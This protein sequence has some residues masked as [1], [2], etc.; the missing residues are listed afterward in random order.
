MP[1]GKRGWN[2]NFEKHITENGTIV[3][4]FFLHISKE[5][6][7]IEAFKKKKTQLEVLSGRFERKRTMG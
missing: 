2:R 6:Q 7:R 1:F 4:K 5:E 3:L